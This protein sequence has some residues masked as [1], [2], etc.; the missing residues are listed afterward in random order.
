MIGRLVHP[1]LGMGHPNPKEIQKIHHLFFLFQILLKVLQIQEIPIPIPIPIST[2]AC[3][4]TRRRP[5]DSYR[6]RT[7]RF[8]RSGHA[9]GWTGEHA[10]EATGLCGRCRGRRV[11]S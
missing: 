4:G 6:T 1:L 2:R 10:S 3:G 8:G 9:Y 7:G 11:D 5:L